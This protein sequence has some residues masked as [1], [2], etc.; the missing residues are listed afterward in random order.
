MGVLHLVNHPAALA[1]CLRMAGGQDAIL[2]LE[3]GVYAGVAD[4]A[5][6]RP[7]HALAVDVTARGL[8]ER[9]GADVTVID[10]AG[11][12]ALVETHSPVVTWR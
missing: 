5:P 1:D 7:L 11:F 8:D 2:L 4:T 6:D 9:L 10:D 12:V 3:N